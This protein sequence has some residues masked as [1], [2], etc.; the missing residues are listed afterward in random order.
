MS[1]TERPDALRKLNAIRHLGSA[2]AED[3]LDNLTMLHTSVVPCYRELDATGF[4]FLCSACQLTLVDRAPCEAV[5]EC[6]RAIDA[7][8]EIQLGRLRHQMVK[9]V[10]K[11]DDGDVLSGFLEIVQSAKLSE[12]PQALTD[13]VC[14][15]LVH[16]LAEPRAT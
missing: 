7:G 5:R 6:L 11:R 4:A 1:V 10:I 9:G 13:K 2:I 3:A 12:L 8:L 16:L 15:H 14:N